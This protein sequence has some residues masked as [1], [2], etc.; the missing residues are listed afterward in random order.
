V[1]FV[2][3]QFS[4][5]A[6]IT[7]DFSV[8]LTLTN[9]TFKTDPKLVLKTPITAPLD[10]NI[11]QTTAAAGGSSVTY[12]LAITAG[13]N[14]PAI[15]TIYIGSGFLIEIDETEFTTAGTKATMEVTFSPDTIGETKI[16]TL[17]ESVAG[18]AVTMVTAPP[19]NPSEIDVGAGGTKFDPG[20]GG[21][22]ERAIIGTIMTA[23]G[24]PIPNNTDMT[25]SWA[26]GPSTITT[27]GNLV[28]TSGPFDN[29]PTD[30][31]VFIDI[32]AADCDPTAT[33]IEATLNGDQATFA[34][35]DA[36]VGTDFLTPAKPICI[37]VPDDNAAKIT[38]T[39]NPPQATLTI[40]YAGNIELS[41]GPDNLR[42]IKNNGAICTVYN[43]TDL[44][45]ADEAWVR[46][47]N[48]SNT[49]GAI[50][51]TLVGQNGQ[52]VFED[53]DLGAFAAS[54]SVGSAGLIGLNAANLDTN[55]K[56]IGKGTLVFNSEYLV[57]LAKQAP[58]PATGEYTTWKRGVLTVSS[59]I[60]K[61]QLEVFLLLQ[62][63]PAAPQMNMSAG[64]SG[65]GCQ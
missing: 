32:N 4:E 14:I 45:A 64:A 37:V 21:I 60:S 62:S 54:T 13:K 28:I 36:H 25:S 57:E 41:F 5:S 47:T 31:K 23:A 19:T 18:T 56:L 61:N 20:V 33:N 30:A 27:S 44:T 50:I 46:I 48:K 65:S 11:V 38:E 51:G 12:S 1:F 55:D 16:V 10:V 52:S 34:L 2:T 58:L 17:V 15:E 22:P 42:H 26:F 24:A 9:A 6:D 7:T 3:Y 40:T 35:T 29:L 53:K 59:S 49:P 43:V 8:T 39:E 63:D